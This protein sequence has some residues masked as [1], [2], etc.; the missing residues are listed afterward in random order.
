MVRTVADQM[1]DTLHAAGAPCVGDRRGN[2]SRTIV[3]GTQRVGHRHSGRCRTAQRGRSAG[4]ETARNGR[5]QGCPLRPGDMETRWAEA[6]YMLKAILNGRTDEVFE[7]APSN[8][9]R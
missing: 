3:P 9:L 5:Y 4:A 7:L 8:L 6:L 1:V 2:A